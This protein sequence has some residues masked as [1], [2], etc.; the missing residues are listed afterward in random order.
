MADKVFNVLFLC[1]RNAA[2]SMLAKLILHHNRPG[3]PQG[4]PGGA[5]ARTTP[6]SRICWPCTFCSMPVSSL[7]GCAASRGT[8]WSTLA[9]PAWT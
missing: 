2:R 5:T 9:R 8:S 6:S 7:G 4:L 3:T 1:I